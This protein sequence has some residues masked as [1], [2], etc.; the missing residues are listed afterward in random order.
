MGD[1]SHQL[2]AQMGQMVAGG[3]P[4]LGAADLSTPPVNGG[5]AHMMSPGGVVASPGG[6][7]A[8]PVRTPEDRQLSQWGYHETR[9]FIALRAELEKDYLQ[10]KT[11]SKTMWEIISAKMKEKGYRRT[12]AQCKCKW[13]VLVNRYKASD[14]LPL[15]ILPVVP[16]Y[17]WLIISYY[18]CS[19]FILHFVMFIVP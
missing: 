18:P 19:F 1:D 4:G 2:A 11:N 7:V 3:I 8:A 6:V 14:F 15:P 12:P 16:V 10:T 5:G 17:Q 9:E 13:K